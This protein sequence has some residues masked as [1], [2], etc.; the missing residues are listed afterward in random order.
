MGGVKGVA[1]G[2]ILPE[3]QVAAQM[4]YLSRQQSRQRSSYNHLPPDTDDGLFITFCFLVSLHN[5]CTVQFFH[6]LK[7][8]SLALQ[9]HSYSEDLCL[10]C[11]VETKDLRLKQ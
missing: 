2:T 7:Q 4:A 9:S 10:I 6:N 11:I 8:I 3:Y 1:Q 5:P